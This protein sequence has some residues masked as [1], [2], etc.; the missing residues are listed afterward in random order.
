MIVGFA[1]TPLRV[2]QRDHEVATQ[3]LA[4]AIVVLEGGERLLVVFC[5]FFESEAAERPLGGLTGIGDRLGRLAD[6][7]RRHPMTSQLIDALAGARL[8]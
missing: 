3:Q 7:R 1:G 5:R 6:R 4:V 2:G 8:G